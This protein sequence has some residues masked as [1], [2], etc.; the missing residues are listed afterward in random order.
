MSWDLTR[1]GEYQLNSGYASEMCVFK[2]ESKI[3]YLE[4]LN[5]LAQRAFTDPIHDKIKIMLVSWY[6]ILSSWRILGSY[7][8]R[9]D[10]YP[11]LRICIRNVC[12]LERI[13]IG[14]FGIQDLFAQWV[15]IAPAHILWSHDENQ[16]VDR[17]VKRRI[18][19]VLLEAAGEHWKP[20]LYASRSMTQTV[21]ICPNW[22]RMFR[23]S[24]W[25]REVPQ[26]HIWPTHL[27]RRDRPSS[28]G[29]HHQE[30][31]E[32][33]VAKDP[34]PNDENAEMRLWTDLYTRKTWRCTLTSTRREQC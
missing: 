16:S 30:E 11:Q 19:S 28:I 25:I 18:C 22:K 20:V 4:I 8:T 13:K 17:C 5:P 21:S 23:A 10:A 14:Y 31:P 2:R 7:L 33:D 32:W 15:T 27:H 24:V 34:A 26:L 29:R 9:Y 1:Y 6:D 12:I 3:R